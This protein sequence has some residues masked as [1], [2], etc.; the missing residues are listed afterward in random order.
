[1]SAWPYYHQRGQDHHQVIF[2]ADDPFVAELLRVY[3]DAIKRSGEAEVR[4]SSAQAVLRYVTRWQHFKR[5]KSSTKN[6]AVQT[7]TSLL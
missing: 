4:V 5:A 3:V 1:M 7:T 2:D 6:K